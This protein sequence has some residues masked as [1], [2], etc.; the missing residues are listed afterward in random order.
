M[1][2]VL[3]VPQPVSFCGL[4][5][6]PLVFP[7]SLSTHSILPSHQQPLMLLGTSMRLKVSARE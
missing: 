7:I 4:V 5:S 1:P 2:S 3:T 6:H